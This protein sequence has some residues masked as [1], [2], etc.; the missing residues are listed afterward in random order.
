MHRKIAVCTSQ[1]PGGIAGRRFCPAVVPSLRT[2]RASDSSISPLFS[3][4]LLSLSSVFVGW[5]KVSLYSP[6]W[7]WPSPLNLPGAGIYRS[8]PTPRV[9]LSFF[10]IIFTCLCFC[11]FLLSFSFSF[12]SAFAMATVCT[13]WLAAYDWQLMIYRHEDWKVVNFSSV[14]RAEPTDAS[15]PLC[16]VSMA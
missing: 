7:S 8:M 9:S 16:R 1:F 14:Q 4:S 11:T 15:E 5:D 3:T 10:A 2:W 12:P 13:V 6:C